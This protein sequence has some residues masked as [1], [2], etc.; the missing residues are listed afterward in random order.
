MKILIYGLGAIGSVYAGL[1]KLAGHEVW[2]WDKPEIIAAI[3]KRGLVIEGIWGE[4]S[5]GIDEMISTIDQV[6]SNDFDLILVA[7]KA[8]DTETAVKSIKPLVGADTF[9]VFGQNGFGNY[10][11]AIK[12]I[13]KERIII[14]RIIF[15][16]ETIKPGHTKVSVI[17]DDVLLGSPEELVPISILD[18][19]ATE[20]NSAGI[21]TRVE[22]DIMHFIWGKIIYN[23]ALN[24]LGAIF[25]TNYG[26]LAENRHTK[27]I[28]DDVIDEIFAVLS[29][30]GQLVPW[31]DAGEYRSAFYTQLVPAT[32][33]HFS[34]M[35]QDIRLGRKT[36]IDALNG[37]VM[38]LG[39]EMQIATPVNELI[40]ELLKA[41]ELLGVM[42]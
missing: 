7:V 35:L 15:G 20:F 6:S 28:M 24:P 25:E 8:F 42:K 36:E 10:E 41:K 23:S 3:S 21:P 4:Y 22:K 29:A 2:G 37:A 13:D 12:Y 32:A 33:G 30:R 31:K 1:M 39:K 9:V 19:F 40:V 27:T 5:T 11:K 18:S 14:A 26:S 17:A 38:Q 16:A 34:S